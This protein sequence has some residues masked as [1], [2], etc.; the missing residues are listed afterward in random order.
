MQLG[1]PININRWIKEN[2]DSLKPPICNKVVFKDDG[3]IVMIIGGPNERKDYHIN[4]GPEL[5][6]QLQGDMTLK[7]VQD[8]EF[9]SITIA[10][11][12]MFQLPPLVPHSPQRF[13]NTVGLVVEQTREIGVLDTLV[14]YCRDCRNKLY[15]E[16]FQLEDITKDLQPIFARYN[17]EYSNDLCANCVV[18]TRKVEDEIC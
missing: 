6:Y 5:F 16:S 14:W 13:S 8:G 10:E 2:E 1:M 9:K 17:E 12:E 11:G 18:E 15:K 7:V 3:Y 4:N